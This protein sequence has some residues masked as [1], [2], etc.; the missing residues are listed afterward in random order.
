LFDF[1]NP[2]NNEFLAVNQFTILAKQ[3]PNRR[4]DIILFV[5]GLPL[6]VIELKNPTG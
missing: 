4:P 2:K 5:N 1:E 3:P 6:V